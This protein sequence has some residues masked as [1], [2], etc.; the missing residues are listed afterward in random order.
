MPISLPSATPRFSAI[1]RYAGGRSWQSSTIWTISPRS[2]GCG[3]CPLSARSEHAAGQA[4][5]L[6]LAGEAL[7]RLLERAT[8][9]ITTSLTLSTR[10][11]SGLCVL[12]AA[13]ALR[14]AS[15]LS[16]ASVPWPLVINQSVASVCARSA[17]RHEPEP[18][19]N[20]D[21]TYHTACCQHGPS[22]PLARY[23]VSLC[24]L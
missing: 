12:P 18:R 20:P 3:R 5:L 16:R 15:Q 23:G 24:P 7:Q 6:D 14:R 10:G 13:L 22:A 8:L 1:F 21:T 17:G 2:S 4:I 19:A 9:L 11:Q